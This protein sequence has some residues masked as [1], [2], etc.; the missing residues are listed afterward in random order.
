MADLGISARWDRELVAATGG[1]AALLIRV[2]APPAIKEANGNGRAPI[3]VA[4]VLDRSG[5][6]AGD[7]LALV[8]EAVQLAVRQLTEADRAALVIYD[9][10]VQ[11]LTH[12]T[13]MTERGR[14]AVQLALRHVESGGSTNLGEGWLTGCRELSDQMSNGPVRLRRSLLLTDG[15]ANVGMTDPAELTHHAQELRRRGVGTTTLGVGLDF[16]E[17]LLSGMAE[18]AS[19]SS[20][21][22]NCRRSLPA[23]WA[24]C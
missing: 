10:Q 6:M 21:P 15:L 9:N 19:S 12:L 8:K 1:E 14:A 18:A 3:D 23:S 22:T 11:T 17:D 7:K 5:S 20:G 16:D 24:S 2:V 4:F 13:S